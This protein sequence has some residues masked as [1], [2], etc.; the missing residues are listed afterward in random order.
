V[1]AGFPSLAATE[2]SIARMS[3]AGA[4]VIEIGIPFSDPIADGPVIAES[5]H[6]ALVGGVTPSL[7]FEMV[8]RVRVD[9][10]AALVAMVSISIVDRIGR[11]RFLDQCAA[12]GVDGVIVPDL[13]LDE[14]KALGEQ[15]CERSL[16]FTL[17]I[18]PT[19]TPERVA[20]I[21]GLCRGF[22]YALARVGL[23]GE[24]GA[25]PSGLAERVALIR[26]SSDLPIAVGFGIS[27]AAQVRSVLAHADGAIVG[28]AL[29]R[30]MGEARDP[31]EAAE[32]FVRELA[33]GTGR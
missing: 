12:S 27:D 1:T 26:R 10:E 15:C 8:A 3:R 6:R 5:M 7:I 14:A 17:L 24:R 32:T 11:D 30:R 18:S 4:D 28:S 20:R 31:A 13:D 19:S 2:A 29:V 22:V 16:T 9:V 25:L 23:T 33:T 21:A